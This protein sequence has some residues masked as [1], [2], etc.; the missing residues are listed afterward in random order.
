MFH[1]RL[2]EEKERERV[3]QERL[4]S[5]EAE[6][7]RVRQL[8][9]ERR[10]MLL[11]T[12]V[13]LEDYTSALAQN[14]TSVSDIAMMKLELLHHL[15]EQTKQGLLDDVLTVGEGVSSSSLPVSSAFYDRQESKQKESLSLLTRAE[16]DND[17]DNDADGSRGEEETGLDQTE[18]RMGRQSFGIKHTDADALYGDLGSVYPG[19][20]RMKYTKRRNKSMTIL[21]SHSVSS[22]LASASVS[23]SKADT[24]KHKK[25]PRSLGSTS[26]K[27]SQIHC[28]ESSVNISSGSAST[29]RADDFSATDVDVS[30]F[31]TPN[32][33]STDISTYIDN[34]LSSSVNSSMSSNNQSLKVKTISL[35]MVKGMGSVVDTIT[36]SQRRRLSMLTQRVLSSHDN[37]SN[38]SSK[39]ERGHGTG[40]MN[41]LNDDHIDDDENK[42]INDGER[43]DRDTICP[44]DKLITS[45][46]LKPSLFSQSDIDHSCDADD[47]RGIEGYESQ[48]KSA[49]SQNE[50]IAS[51]SISGFAR[52]QTPSDKYPASPEK[53]SEYSDQNSPNRYLYKLSTDRKI[54]RL[55]KS[56]QR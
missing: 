20:N 16:N 41:R 5:L 3:I 43:E 27:H 56:R 11:K 25:R 50:T 14:G 7:A 32:N 38:N 29:A 6:Q 33:D 42:K 45:A 17:D 39:G 13:E 53:P 40:T 15:Q 55:A 10:K 44:D 31:E 19:R 28:N 37:G 23:V 1:I 51:A 46:S 30:E 12:F 26:K 22:V 21:P 48:Y 2:E 4:S 18:S 35:G 54:Q 34:T 49:S 9:D 24:G 47:S 52:Q 36:T 8:G